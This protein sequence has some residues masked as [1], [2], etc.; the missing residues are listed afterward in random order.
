MIDC[1][2]TSHCCPITRLPRHFRDINLPQHCR[3]CTFPPTTTVFLLWF[4]WNVYFESFVELYRV[5]HDG[6]GCHFRSSGMDSQRGSKKTKDLEN[7]TFLAFVD[8]SLVHIISLFIMHD[9][10][11]SPSTN[12]LIFFIYFYC[13]L[14]FAFVGS[15]YFL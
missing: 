4:L 14:F 9:E 11:P 8:C 7:Y 6:I 3:T 5:T 10:S 13:G 2:T 1:A 15:V 12:L